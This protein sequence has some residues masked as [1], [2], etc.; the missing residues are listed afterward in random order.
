MQLK[1][2]IVD[3]NQENLYSMKNLL[4]TEEYQFVLASSGEAALQSAIKKDIALILLDVQMPGMDGYEVARILKS[5]KKTESIPIIFIT[6]ID[7]DI[8]NIVRG[9]DVGALDFIF[10]PVNPLLLRA[11]VKNLV[12]LHIA[13]SELLKLNHELEEKVFQRT[14]ELEIRNQELKKMN[15]ILDN[16]LH[17]SAHDFRNPLSNI[18]LITHMI[19]S[20]KSDDERN[21]LLNGLEASIN[22]IEKTIQGIIEM[23]EVQE[24]KN[25]PAKRIHFEELINV[26]LNEFNRAKDEIKA[27]VKF[28]FHE[29]PVISYIPV[30]LESV[31]RN[32]ISNALKYRSPSRPLQ[33]DIK[34]KTE[35]EFVVITFSDNGIGIDL[36]RNRKNLF[37]P[38]S[39]FN[40]EIEGKGIGLHLIKNIVEMNGGHIFVSSVLDSGTTFYV[41]LK[42]YINTISDKKETPTVVG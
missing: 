13:Q 35:G 34:T 9:F 26:I 6:A 21:L 19:K 2:L 30:Y 5:N 33:I 4:E 3:D 41:Y 8:D 24:H 37:K 14:K 12:S 10:K 16:F 20:T 7:H 23:V 29:T 15:E 38:F 40:R 17:V 36:S 28:S 39:R 42:P 25:H 1:I 31:L 27:A 32:L 18:S 11:K 22:M